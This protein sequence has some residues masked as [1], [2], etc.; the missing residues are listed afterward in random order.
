MP[1]VE[2]A[3]RKRDKKEEEKKR[4]GVKESERCGNCGY[5]ELIESR[6]KMVCKKCGFIDQ[7]KT[8]Y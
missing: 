4:E 3:V 1:E 6:G 5:T 7:T 8:V 2:K